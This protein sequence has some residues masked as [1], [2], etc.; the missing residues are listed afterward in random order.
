MKFGRLFLTN[1][2]VCGIKILTS[3]DIYHGKHLKQVIILYVQPV[4]SYSPNK[5]D[6]NVRK[7]KQTHTPN[8]KGDGYIYLIA[9]ERDNI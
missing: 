3:R 6:T 2:T 4:C 8:L 7:H 9:Q 5:P 1:H